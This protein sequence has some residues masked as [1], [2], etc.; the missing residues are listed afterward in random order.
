MESTMQEEA[1]ELD[2]ALE[3]EGWFGRVTLPAEQMSA[4]AASTRAARQRALSVSVVIGLG[5]YV[6][7]A[8][9]DWFAVPDRIRL[10][11][12][13]RLG[14][15]LPL[16]LAV[17][18]WL[19]RA[20]GPLIVQQCVTCGFHLLA[21]AMLAVLM[22]LSSSVNALGFVFANYAVLMAMVISMALPLRLVMILAVIVV[23][24]QSAAIAHGPLR[25]PVLEIHN[26][27]IAIVIIGPALFAHRTLENER[28]RHFLLITREE[29]RK[30]QL[31]E[32]RDMLGRLAALDP[33][34]ELANRRGF[35]AGLA[36]DLERMAPGAVVAMAM[37]DI[38]SFKAYND[39][40]G[41]AA[42]D[43]ALRRVAQALAAAAEPHGRAGRIGGEEFAIFVTGMTGAALAPYAERL[44][45]SVQ[46]LS[47][48]HHHST[49]AGVVTVSIGVALGYA[50]TCDTTRLFEAADAALYR[51]KSAGRNQVMIDDLTRGDAGVSR[52]G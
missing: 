13:L 17:L 31:A 45:A 22:V 4:F 46:G 18:Y 10:A 12:T 43:R 51:A 29:R 27:M 41:H 23:L 35:H 20:R 40:Y 3:G 36:S 25:L 33:L 42:G 8:P 1:T 34:T 9:G 44:R 16:G 11:L 52:A 48:M 19:H 26:L 39:H 5:F 7:F 49:T 2:R 21:V 24:I 47:M 50:E 38:D 32:Q 37:I 30:R 14:V 28:R 6:A 15:V